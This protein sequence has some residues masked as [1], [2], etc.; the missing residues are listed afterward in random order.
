MMIRRIVQLWLLVVFT[1]AA[2]GHAVASEFAWRD[3]QGT[4]Y[5]LRQ[6]AGQAVALHF[7]ASWCAPCRAELPAL[8]AWIERHADAKLIPISL[9]QEGDLAAAF[10]E[11]QGIDLPLLLANIAQAGRLGVRALPT[12]VIVD[13]HG[14]VAK[15]Y[16]GMLPWADAQFSRLFLAQLQSASASR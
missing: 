11:E 16:V 4:N 15:T 1:A 13:G 8:A 2:L 9:D 3:G 7:W 10:L 5:Q 12:T 14:T 6:Y